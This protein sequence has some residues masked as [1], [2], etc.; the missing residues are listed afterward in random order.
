[1]TTDLVRIA[2]DQRRCALYRHFDAYD[3]LL[4]VGISES[5]ED[6]TN[7]HARRSE[8][9]DFAERAEMQWFDSRVLA[10]KAEQESIRDESPVFNRQYATGDVERRIADYLRERE[11]EILADTLRTYE[12]IVRE[13]LAGVPTESVSEATL[14]A[15]ADY[16][17]AGQGADRVFPAHVLRHLK[18]VLQDHKHRAEDAA[19]AEAYA[20]VGEFLGTQ[21]DTIDQRQQPCGPGLS[22]APF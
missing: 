10:A 13:F 8:W 11:V 15:H 2:P 1:M 21:L 17:C 6:R 18:Q 3:V 20:T 14:L 22:E 4:Y 5:P 19:R 9:V 12:A 7:G 16:Q